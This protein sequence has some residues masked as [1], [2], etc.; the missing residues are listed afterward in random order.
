MFV[1]INLTVSQKKDPLGYFYHLIEGKMKSQC[2]L[3]KGRVCPIEQTRSLILE[4]QF[5]L[6][7][8][9]RFYVF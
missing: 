5:S 7:I 1:L 8:V 6:R 4:H 3:I 9:E 2:T